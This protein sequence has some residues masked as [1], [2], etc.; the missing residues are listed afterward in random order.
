[1]PETV[2]MLPN[3]AVKLPVRP[4]TRVADRAPHAPVWPAA[5]GRR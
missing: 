2:K 1:M 3:M 5:Y 4:V